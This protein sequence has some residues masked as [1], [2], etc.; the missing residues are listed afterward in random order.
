MDI[1]L[2]CS[3]DSL[4]NECRLCGDDDGGVGDGI[5][6]ADIG[7]GIRPPAAAAVAAAPGRRRSKYYSSTCCC[8]WLFGPHY[9]LP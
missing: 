5:A 6:S 7:G 1:E 2:F 4:D 3:S 8:I 9:F